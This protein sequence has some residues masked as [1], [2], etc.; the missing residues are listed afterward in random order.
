[1]EIIKLNLIPSGVNPT[2]HCSQYDE[3]RVIRI[4]LFDGLTPYALKSGDTVT[5]NVRKPDNTIV[6]A[7]VTATQGNKYVDIVTTEQICACVGYNLC[8]LTITNGSVVIGTLNFIM[9]VERDVLADGIPSQSVIEDLDALVQEAVGDNYYTKTETDNEIAGL[10]N[11][12]STTNNKTWS[13]SKINSKL[14]P[15]YNNVW[16][17]DIAKYRQ[18][19]NLLDKATVLI[20]TFLNVVDGKVVYIQNEYS[21]NYGVLK[22]DI[23][24]FKE[25]D[26]QNLYFSTIQTPS[27]VPRVYSIFTT[28]RDLNIIDNRYAI[29]KNFPTSIT[30]LDLTGAKYILVNIGSYKQNYDSGNFIMVNQGTSALP[31]EEYKTPIIL[32]YDS[33]AE[34]DIK[35]HLPDK[36]FAVVGDT[37]EIFYKGIINCLDTNLYYVQ[38]TCEKGNAFKEKFIYTPVNDDIGTV[39]FNIRV[40]D[41]NHKLL[42]D[43]ST[44]IIV[45]AKATSPNSEK[46]VLWVGDSLSQ[47]GVAVSEFYRRLTGSGGSPIGD[48]LTNI[49]MIGDQDGTGGAKFVAYGGWTFDNYN[50]ASA[51]NE[52]MWIT[53]THDKTSA[54]QHS[55]YKDANNKQWKLETIDN[56]KIKIIRVSTTGTLPSTGT[57][58]WV[59]GGV[60]HSDIVYTASEQASG[61]PFWNSNTSS[62]DFNMFVTEQG[63]STL[64]YVFVLL[65]WNSATIDSNT[66]ATQVQT[67]I[68]N[69]RA[70]YPSCKIILLGLEIPSLDGLG[71]N[72]K[73]RERFSYYYNMQVVWRFEEIYKTIAENNTNIVYTQVSGQFDTIHN[74]QTLTRAVNTRNATTET[75]QSNGIHPATSG[76]LQISDVAYREFV[77]NELQ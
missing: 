39:N 35:I 24:L 20:G 38:V 14:T 41:G 8:D 67:F 26:L 50:K 76:Y 19:N 16:V 73:A 6:T 18:V 5:L 46:V 42:D 2:C 15:L 13:A 43:A 54:D 48:E 30:N 37:L 65:G 10:I 45:K 27:S 40:Y 71:N 31:Y 32:P 58:Q 60:N 64:D 56:D 77:V 72:Y 49:A 7:S 51:S 11:D 57:L 66:Y 63:K 74:M 1:M 69:V 68:N 52:F 9:Q 47:N 70:S 53:T 28:D 61:N 3:G 4:E 36:Y 62:V 59:S 29:N 55:I 33:T 21:G 17:D 12:T 22:L 44:S 23:E 34:N 25:N 75:Y